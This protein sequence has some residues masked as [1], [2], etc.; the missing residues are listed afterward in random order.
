[1]TPTL[2]K[3]L[4]GSKVLSLIYFLNFSSPKQSFQLNSEI[5]ILPRNLSISFPQNHGCDIL[6]LSQDQKYLNKKRKVWDWTQSRTFF[7]P[8]ECGR[9]AP[10]PFYC[11]QMQKLSIVLIDGEW[12]VYLSIYKRMIALRTQLNY[13]NLKI[14]LLREYVVQLHY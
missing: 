2:L 9:F 11:D 5:S 10:K 8:R 3:F 1:M 7:L 4:T 14:F 13:S 12:L 6:P